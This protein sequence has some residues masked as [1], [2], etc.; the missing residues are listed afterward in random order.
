MA[1]VYIKTEKGVAELNRSKASIEPRLASLLFM[2]DERKTVD[3]LHALFLKR[4]APDYSLDLLE[5]G[6]FIAK[7]EQ[8]ATAPFVRPVTRLQTQKHA[9]A[10]RPSNGASIEAVVRK[11]ESHAQAYQ[12]L[13]LHLI[14]ASKEHL[15]MVKSWQMQ[16]AIERASNMAQ[17]RALIKPLEDAIARKQG[18]DR[19]N[20][21]RASTEM[22][23]RKISSNVGSLR[24]ASNMPR[25]ALQ[26]L[27]VV[28]GERA[29]G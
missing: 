17:L 2:V 26:S 24:E 14:D 7:L 12:S 3:E 20:A 22:L 28:R 16:M 29:R 6:G 15:G 23:I 25:A 9:L 21:F 19:G 13:Y 27:R 5:L 10:L 1:Q 4:G 11:P 8:W 18:L